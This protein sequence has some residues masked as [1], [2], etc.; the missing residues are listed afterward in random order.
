MDRHDGVDLTPEE[1]A[2]AHARDLAVQGRY[3]VEYHT[4][5]YDLAAGTV[6]CLM[7]GPSKEAVD[8]VHREAHD[9]SANVII[10]IPDGLPLEQLL[11]AVPKTATESATLGPATRAIV[12]TDMCG[13]V[14]QTHR[15]GDDG[16]VALLRVHDRI[17]R[18]E[19]AQHQGREVKHT[20]DGIMSA[21]V[22]VAAAV[23]FAVGVQREVH[24]RNE[25]APDALDVSIGISA[26]EPVTDESQDLFGAA[27]QLAARLCTAA[28]PG[29]IIVSVAV[30][31]LCLGKQFAFRDNGHL[32]LKGFPEPTQTYAVAWP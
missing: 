32:E 13:S 24:T 28:N 3:G 18:Y 22:S 15:L 30:R 9:A 1:L 14:A 31:E 20:G 29:D 23:A 4:V 11:G 8:A 6:F 19:L 7:E 27:V 2:D 16:H 21:F 12:F 26:G 17:V 10:E 25:A 5:W